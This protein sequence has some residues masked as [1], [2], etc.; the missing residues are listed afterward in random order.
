M[1]TPFSTI[2][3][4]I[5]Q[6]YSSLSSDLPYQPQACFVDN[7]EAVE[8]T[9]LGIWIHQHFS[10]TQLSY[11]WTTHHS[12]R[13][14]KSRHTFC[15]TTHMPIVDHWNGNHSNLCLLF[16]LIIDFGNTIL[17]TRTVPQLLI[18]ISLY[19]LRNSSRLL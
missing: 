18:P 10:V 9:E 14:A 5:V 16:C 13:W 1:K 3:M 19:S 11:H 8:G 12:E 6:H 2:S 4:I 7:Q 15:H 17:L